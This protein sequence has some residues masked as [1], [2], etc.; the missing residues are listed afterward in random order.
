MRWS[1]RSGGTSAPLRRAGMAF[2]P[3]VYES[4]LERHL[5]DYHLLTWGGQ[6]NQFRHVDITDEVRLVQDGDVA[7]AIAGLQRVVS[8]E[9]AGVDVPGARTPSVH[10]DGLDERLAD[11]TAALR[12]M[13]PMVNHLR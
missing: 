9:I 2:S 6:T 3:V 4:E 10:I 11:V 5:P 7:A 1:P 12:A 8:E 13:T